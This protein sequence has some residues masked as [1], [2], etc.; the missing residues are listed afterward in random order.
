MRILEYW[1]MKFSDKSYVRICV[2]NCV[3]HATNLLLFRLRLTRHL[4][5]IFITSV[6]SL[7]HVNPII[8]A[9]VKKYLSCNVSFLMGLDFSAL[10]NQLI[11]KKNMPS[12]NVCWASTIAYPIIIIRNKYVIT[13]LFTYY[14]WIWSS[15]I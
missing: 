9:Y 13:Y 5:I 14:I 1:R 10:L 2:G 12:Y 11:L 6:D 3:D 15:L 4:L 8:H 7:G